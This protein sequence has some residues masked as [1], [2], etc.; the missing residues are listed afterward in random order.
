MDGPQN[1][2]GVA[3]RPRLPEHSAPRQQRLNSRS[4][5]CCLA[6]A[7]LNLYI[8]CGQLVLILELILLFIAFLTDLTDSPTHIYNEC[9]V[10]RSILGI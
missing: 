2:S 7:A 5:F 3:A 9:L 1:C 4:H 6:M 10:C 8:G